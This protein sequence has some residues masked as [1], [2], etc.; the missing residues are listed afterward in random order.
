MAESKSTSRLQ[1]QAT[2][3][4]QQAQLEAEPFSS[5]EDGIGSFILKQSKTSKS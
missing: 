2:L 4:Q 1:K 5:F 3:L